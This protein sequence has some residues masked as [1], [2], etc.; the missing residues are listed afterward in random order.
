[1]ASVMMK[2]LLYICKTPVVLSHHKYC[3][4]GGSH[5]SAMSD[6]QLDESNGSWNIKDD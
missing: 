4:N 3:K 2:G 5:W 6:L 1:M